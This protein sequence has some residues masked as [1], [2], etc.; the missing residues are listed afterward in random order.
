MLLARGLLPDRICWAIRSR[1]PARRSGSQ[2]RFAD[3]RTIDVDR[4]FLRLLDQAIPEA[5]RH[6]RDSETPLLPQRLLVP[7]GER[8]NAL[9]TA[10]VDATVERVT[11]RRRS[12][13][14]GNSISS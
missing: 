4:H 13:A 6:V 3:L 1:S 7:W 5:P 12:R 9:R 11:E 10:I 8:I 2:S 14:S